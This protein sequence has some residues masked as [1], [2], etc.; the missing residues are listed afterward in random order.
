MAGG[1]GW[2]PL[3]R[4][5]SRHSEK[6]LHSMELDAYKIYKNHQFLLYKPKFSEIPIFRI[7]SKGFSI[8][9]HVSL[10]IDYRKLGNE[11]DVTVT[12]LLRYW[13]LFLYVLKKET[14]SYTMVPIKCMGG[15]I[16]SS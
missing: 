5:S 12:S 15:F 11:Y 4:I 13:Y 10:K 1:G 7:F 2:L 14:P 8:L 16:L 9:A 3:Q 6:Y